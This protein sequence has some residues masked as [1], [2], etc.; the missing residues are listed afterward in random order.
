MTAPSS[1]SAAPSTRRGTERVGDERAGDQPQRQG[2][3]TIVVGA[4]AGSRYGGLKQYE[5]LAG[6]R[7]IDRS[8]RTAEAASEGVVMVVPATDAEREGGVAGGSTRTES[9]RAGLAGVP[10]SASIVLVHDA[11]RPLATSALFDR[12]IDAVVAGADAAI[13]SLPVTDTVKVVEAGVVVATADRRSLVTVQTP[14]AFRATLLRRAYRSHADATDDAALVELAGGT[15]SVV[16]GETT[17]IK[18]TGP[19][20]LAIAE[21]FLMRLPFDVSDH[22][23]DPDPLVAERRESISDGHEEAR[24]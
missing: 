10:S 6:E 21:A 19:R 4:G 13:P 7:V 24:W 1:A 2:V 18:I 11:A 9:V 17:N 12:V 8:R 20:D 3:W 15:V 23:S 16:D 22:G 5:L 14:Q